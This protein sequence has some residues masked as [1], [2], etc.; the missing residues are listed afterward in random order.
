MIILGICHSN[1]KLLQKFYFLA[2]CWWLML[3]VIVIW[4]ADIR[5][6][7]VQGQ[8]GKIVCGILSW[9]CPTQNGASRVAQVVKR[10]PN[11]HDVKPQYHQNIF[12][13]ILFLK[14]TFQS[15]KFWTLVST[16]WCR[17]HFSGPLIPI[18]WTGGLVRI[19]LIWFCQE[20]FID[21]ICKITNLTAMPGGLKD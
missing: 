1:R 19:D 13:H 3:I 15:Y 6:V 21:E 5:R 16:R 2:G 7:A 11:K 9:Q 20:R 10:P 18:R 12:F 4:E 17:N 8:Q 14:R